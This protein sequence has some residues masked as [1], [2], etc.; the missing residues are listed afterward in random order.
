MRLTAQEAQ[1]LL[2][3]YIPKAKS[4]HHMPCATASVNK[5]FFNG[6]KLTLIV[7]P[8]WQWDDQVNLYIPFHITGYDV[9]IY[10]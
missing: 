6:L 4:T 8:D 2:Q 7:R 9:K 3:A 5:T 10:V 1:A